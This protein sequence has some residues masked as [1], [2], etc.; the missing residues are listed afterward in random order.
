MAV[1]PQPAR[2]VKL[3]AKAERDQRPLKQ[4]VAY[5]EVLSQKGRVSITASAVLI[6][7]AL[8]YIE[9]SK[10]PFFGAALEP[11]DGGPII[12]LLAIA[13]L[14]S[15]YRFS[16]YKQIVILD[17]KMGLLSVEYA[18]M[19]LRWRC[20]RVIRKAFAHA[21]QHGNLDT[22]P[23]EDR[24]PADD[25]NED[26]PEHTGD[27]YWPI[28]W[29]RYWSLDHSSLDDFAWHTER[30][31]AFRG[32]V[33]HEEIRFSSHY[34]FANETGRSS[35]SMHHVWMMPMHQ[36]TRLERVC[37]L[38]AR[39]RLPDFLEVTFPTALFVSAMCVAG[40]SLL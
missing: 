28:Y 23:D 21:I 13:A 31:L 40:W 30:E 19:F 25:I 7:S 10:L 34:V 17:S 2:V 4:S 12:G 26:W 29:L 11:S 18:K 16:A 35:S 8:G 3:P 22:F 32:D 5:N 6:L 15:W 38:L 9:L 24:T 36:Y 14:Y 39:L 20:G 37:K 27:S 1:Q 33:S